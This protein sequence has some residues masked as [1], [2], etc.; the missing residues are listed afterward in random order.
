[1]RFL[2]HAPG[3]RRLFVFVSL[4]EHGGRTGLRLVIPD[5]C[6]GNEWIACYISLFGAIR[7]GNCQSETGID[8]CIIGHLYGIP[9]KG[10]PGLLLLRV[11][12]SIRIYT[13]Y[14]EAGAL[15]LPDAM[16]FIFRPGPPEKWAYIPFNAM[17]A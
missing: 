8:R 12:Y 11:G 13:L 5:W 2:R 4:A 10:I 16:N 3:V 6:R 14:L 17:M 7:P 9:V 1:M 15:T